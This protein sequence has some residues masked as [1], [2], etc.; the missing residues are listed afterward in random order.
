MFQL[1]IMVIASTRD[2]EN[3]LYGLQIAYISLQSVF[4]R[5][6]TRVSQIMANL[7]AEMRDSTLVSPKNKTTDSNESV[8]YKYLRIRAVHRYI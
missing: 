6:G 3:W 1:C 7:S 5:I 4:Y 2:L 8:V